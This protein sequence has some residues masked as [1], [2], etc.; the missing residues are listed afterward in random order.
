MK[1]SNKKTKKNTTIASINSKLDTIIQL[2]NKI[3]K[4]NINI[5]KQ[6]NFVY[7]EEKKISKEKEQELEQISA[8]NKDIDSTKKIEEQEILELK[9]LEEEIKKETGDHPLKKFGRKDIIKGFV[10]AFIGLVVHYTFFYGIKIS[11]NIDISRATFLFILAFFVGVLF[12]YATGFRKIKDPKILAFIPLRLLALYIISIIMSIMVLYLF[13]PK[14]GHDFIESYKMTS[15]VLIAA[16][17]GACTA[18]IVG[19]E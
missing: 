8:I 16:I 18:D 13:Y 5:E 1:K 11:E 10:G 17:I 4:E 6:E 19:K 9:R 7:E 15:V 3:L 14:F 2:Q 12:L